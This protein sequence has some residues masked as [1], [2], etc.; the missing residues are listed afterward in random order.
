MPINI[1]NNTELQLPI[2]RLTRN[3]SSSSWVQAD[4]G[5]ETPYKIHRIILTGGDGANS[6]GVPNAQVRIRNLVNNTTRTSF[7]FRD[8]L[9]AVPFYIGE[10]I[11]ADE[12]LQINAVSGTLEYF[13]R[14]VSNDELEKVKEH[15][16]LQRQDQIAK[17]KAEKKQQKEVKK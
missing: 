7:L 5:I 3:S 11:T 14:K 1:Y 8:Y 4:P 9:A 12:S 6:A 2:K 15:H 17:E 13:A 16:K 10:I